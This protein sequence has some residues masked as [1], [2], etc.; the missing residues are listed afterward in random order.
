MIESCF[1]SRVVYNG[2]CMVHVPEGW[3]NYAMG[4]EKLEDESSSEK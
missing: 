4:M 1:K 3:K 2:A